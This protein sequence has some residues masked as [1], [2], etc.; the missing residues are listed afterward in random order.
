MKKNLNAHLVF[1]H[2]RFTE[3]KSKWAQHTKL[4]LS[5]QQDLNNVFTRIRALQQK[6]EKLY[7]DEYIVARSEIVNE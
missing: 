3:T 7:P 6:M 4:I 2:A 5:L 1:S